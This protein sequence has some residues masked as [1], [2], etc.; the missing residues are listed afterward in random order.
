MPSTAYPAL[1]HIA[2]PV[3]TAVADATITVTAQMSKGRVISCDVSLSSGLG[4]H[5]G[6]TWV[7]GSIKKAN[8]A[9]SGYVEFLFYNDYAPLGGYAIVPVNLRLDGGELLVLELTSST[10]TPGGTATADATVRHYSPDDARDADP[11]PVDV[12]PWTPMVGYERGGRGSEVSIALAQPAA[13]ADYATQSPGAKTWWRIIG[14]NVKLVAAVGVFNRQLQIVAEDA[15]SKEF[16]SKVNPNPVTSGQTI[17]TDL[18]IG[19]AAIDQAPIGGRG[20][21]ALSEIWIP[22]SGMVVFTTNALQAGD[23]YNAGILRVEEFVA[24]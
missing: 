1:E 17:T 8:P 22:P 14:G 4:Q 9:G 7:R 19:A 18:I 5:R 12:H 6:A 23:Q 2:S 24:A 10:N 20:A 16:A 11:D 13:G 3:A 15:G 21:M